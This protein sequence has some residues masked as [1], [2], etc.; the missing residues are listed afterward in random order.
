M[1]RYEITWWFWSNELIKLKSS[2]RIHMLFFF[3]LFAPKNINYQ[4]EQI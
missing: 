1:E 3:L 2:Q 4:L